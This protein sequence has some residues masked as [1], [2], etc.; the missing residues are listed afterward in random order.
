MT[1]EELIRETEISSP[2]GRTTRHRGRQP[3]LTS[4]VGS[5]SVPEW[6]G[7]F[8]TDFQRGRISAELLNEIHETAIKS[9]LIDQEVAGLDVVSDG[10]FRR[11]NDM[12]YFI[13]RIDGIE[14]SGRPKEY[15]F[16][17]YGATV[18]GPLPLPENFAGFGL[19]D[20]LEFLKARTTRGVTMSLPGAYSLSRRITNRSKASDAEIVLALA[21]LI[22]TEAVRLA[23][24]GATRI[25]LDEPYLAGHPDQIELAVAAVNIVTAGVDTH[26]ALHVCYGNRYARP[27]WEGHYDFLFPA[28]L[29]AGIDELVLEFGRKGLDDLD[30]FRRFPN[31]FELGAGVIDVKSNNVETPEMVADRLYQALKV[32]PP[33]R[34]VVNPDCGLRH[35][36]SAVARAKLESMVAGAAIVRADVLGERG[37]SRGSGRDA[38]AASSLTPAETSETPADG[39]AVGNASDDDAGRAPDG[40]S[41]PTPS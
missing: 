30:L 36:P 22:H 38:L 23:A 4:V 18:S 28:V 16:D 17:Y 1:T 2:P 9:A 7:R 19:V 37:H 35:L 29:D 40:A 27:A 6:L 31:T 39:D 25:Q 11:D 21:S 20:D 12:D 34:L 3:L 33:E 8:N 14:L 13:E 10:E 32:L 41:A 5:Y 24:A 15:Y 26:V